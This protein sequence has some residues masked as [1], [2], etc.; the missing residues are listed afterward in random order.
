MSYTIYHQSLESATLT[1]SATADTNYPVT[2]LQDRYKNT[3]FKDTAIGLTEVNIKVDFGTART[4]NYIL[5]WN[6]LITPSSGLINLFSLEYSST[7]VFGGEQG[8]AI[9]L[10]YE[11]IYKPSLGNYLKTFASKSYRYWRFR[12]QSADSIIDKLQIG[13]IYLGAQITL[14]HSPEIGIVY[15]AD[16]DVNVNQG[17]GGIRAGSINNATVRRIWQFQ[18]KLLNPT[19]KTNLETFRDSVFMNKG[20]S[21]YPFIWSPN[22]GATLYS[23]R[24]NGELSLKQTAFEAYEWNAVFEEEL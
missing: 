22:S 20:L 14:S 6:Y 2:N 7:G 11:N 3:F 8:T 15:S 18:W 13:A 9:P 19:D 23:A 24:T 21:R 17:A 12:F 4:C 10:G 1:Y 5:F 16:Y